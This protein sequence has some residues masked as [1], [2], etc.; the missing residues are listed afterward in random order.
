MSGQTEIPQKSSAARVEVAARA[1]YAL[2]AP[3][4]LNL[5][6]HVTGRR[7]DG[8]HLLESHFILI[9]LADL[10]DFEVLKTAEIVR[11]GDTV[12]DPEKDLCVRAARLLQEVSLSRT[13]KTPGARIHVV[14]NIPAGAGLGGGSSDAALT[15][16]A[17]NRLWGLDLTRDEL[18]ELGAKLGAD[19]PFFIF[20]R[21]AFAAGIG[22]QLTPLAVPDA[23][24]VVAMPSTPTSTA[25]VFADPALTRNT[26]SLKISALSEK[27]LHQ[28]PQLAGRND[29]EEAACRI[30]PDIARARSILGEG[31][32]MTGSGSAV[33]AWCRDEDQARRKIALLPPDIRGYAVRSLHEHPAARLL[34]SR[35]RA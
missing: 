1:F 26:K 28:W 14:K 27:L 30:N 13:G 2:P 25:A 9:D 29:L 33:F 17:L 24:W 20:G 35:P 8:M 19:I 21:D 12:G 31:A 5:F 6:L 10:L 22:E 23:L 16:M 34:E 18:I 32:R 11:T 7:A 15:L 3:A 4:K